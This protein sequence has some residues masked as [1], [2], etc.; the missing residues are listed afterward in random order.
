[1]I[2]NLWTSNENDDKDTTT[3]PQTRQGSS[4]WMVYAIDTEYVAANTALNLNQVC[5]IAYWCFK[6]RF[7][8]V[9]N[10]Y[11]FIL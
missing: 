2:I 6:D 5:K 3:L 11:S 10:G 1:M 8:I 4:I 7:H 9:N